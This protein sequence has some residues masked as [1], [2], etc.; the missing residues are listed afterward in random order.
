MRKTTQKQGQEWSILLSAWFYTSFKG[1]VRK[2]KV[3]I[4]KVPFWDSVSSGPMSNS[5][6][7]DI[8]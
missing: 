7:A 2:G 8:C 6:I 4:K 5:S 3:A 1:I